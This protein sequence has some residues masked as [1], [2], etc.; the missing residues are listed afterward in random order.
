M[1]TKTLDI[2]GGM[3]KNDFTLPGYTNG[4][5]WAIL[6]LMHIFL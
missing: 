2:T 1:L 6:I 4:P 5:Q 3:L